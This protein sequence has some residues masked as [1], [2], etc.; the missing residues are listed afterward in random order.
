[1]IC[2]ST[3]HIYACIKYDMS[4][5]IST[6]TTSMNPLYCITE[7]FLKIYRKAR[8]CLTIGKYVVLDYQGVVSVSEAFI[9]TAPENTYRVKVEEGDLEFYEQLYKYRHVKPII[10][11]DILKEFEK[12]VLYLAEYF[13][14]NIELQIS[15]VGLETPHAICD[16]V[17]YYHKPPNSPLTP[18]MHDR[19]RDTLDML[20]NRINRKCHCLLMCGGEKR[21]QFSPI[22]TSF[23]VYACRCIYKQ[24]EGYYSN[25]G[26]FLQD[27][28]IHMDLLK[29]SFGWEGI[30]GFIKP[31]LSEK[32]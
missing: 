31:G 18:E 27:R 5:D 22:I 4:Q 29:G 26:E 30:Y 1:M 10:P 6:N 17:R 24:L 23:N 3:H 25:V 32:L 21:W 9:E 8:P 11:K 16:Y 28:D 19:I 14:A 15:I 2:V 13:D 12:I 20:E 7:D